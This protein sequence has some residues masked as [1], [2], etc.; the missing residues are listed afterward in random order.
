MFFASDFPFSFYPAID[1]DFLG[2]S[3]R[4]SVL[5]Q[6]LPNNLVDVKSTSPDLIIGHE[7]DVES[8]NHGQLATAF[9]HWHIMRN[10]FP[11][12]FW[13]LY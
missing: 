11:L 7:S 6:I 5:T 9:E 8:F 10:L 4:E 13:L 12:E 1:E 2:S 3:M